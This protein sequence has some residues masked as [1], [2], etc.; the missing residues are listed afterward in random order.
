MSFPQHQVSDFSGLRIYEDLAHPTHIP[1][2][3]LHLVGGLAA[4]TV[5]TFNCGIYRDAY[6]FA[7]S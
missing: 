2:G 3:G 5:G 7:T 6:H 4:V 1:V